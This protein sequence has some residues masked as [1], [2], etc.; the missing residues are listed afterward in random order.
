MATHLMDIKIAGRTYYLSHNG[1]TVYYS[2]SGRGQGSF[3]IKGLR[4]RGNQI[5]DTST[6]KPA[7][8]FL[9]AQKMGK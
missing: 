1:E 6:G 3:S 8:E 7:T 4:F 9:I 5:L 2:S